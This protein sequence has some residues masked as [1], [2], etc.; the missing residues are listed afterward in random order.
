MIEE[1]KTRGE[2]LKQAVKEQF[3]ASEAQSSEF[4]ACIEAWEQQPH[5]LKQIEQLQ[6]DKTKLQE[7]LKKLRAAQSHK[8]NSYMSSRLREALRE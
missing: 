3:Q 2:A 8:E 1:R 5:L 4:I 7:Q 6:A